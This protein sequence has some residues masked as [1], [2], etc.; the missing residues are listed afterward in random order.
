MDDI[1]PIRTDDDLAW[2]VG[3]VEQY[4]DNPPEPGTPESDRFDFLSDLI[5]VYENRYHPIDDLDPI[6]VLFEFMSNNDLS[7]IDLTAVL[8]SRSRASE[9]LNR[10][11]ALNM[12]MVRRISRSWHIPADN[13]IAPYHLAR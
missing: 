4:F 8:G 1:K 5:E 3:E 12:D 6:E 7:Q 2:A 10:K 9:V 11:C 13:L